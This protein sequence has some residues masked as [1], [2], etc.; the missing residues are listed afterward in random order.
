MQGFVFHCDTK[1]GL[2]FGAGC[3]S[4]MTR[5]MP[6]NGYLP[7]VN[8]I[9][10]SLLG[11]R[12]DGVISFSMEI[13]LLA[14]INNVEDKFDD[15]NNERAKREKLCKCNHLTTPFRG[16]FRPP[17]I[18]IPQ[19]SFDHPYSSILCRF[20]QEAPAPHRRGS[21]FRLRAGS[22]ALLTYASRRI[23]RVH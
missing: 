4:I 15:C 6:T 1:S 19:G 11:R 7:F 21:P 23:A 10:P 3:A 2:I 12:V 9:T 20:L 13:T 22:A 14:S 17:L 8:E 5:G 18:G 16:G